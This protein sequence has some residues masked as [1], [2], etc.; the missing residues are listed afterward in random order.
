MKLHQ[1]QIIER[2]DGSH[3]TRTLCGRESGQS[4]DGM[5]IA[6]DDAAVNCLLCIKLRRSRPIRR[7]PTG[8]TFHPSHG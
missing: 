3:T 5:N 1:S 6:D 4:Q 8:N 7:T 2:P